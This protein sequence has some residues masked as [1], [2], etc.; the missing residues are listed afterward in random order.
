MWY[1]GE[2][3]E[4][5]RESMVEAEDIRHRDPCCHSKSTI[6]QHPIFL[7]PTNIRK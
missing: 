1:S 2:N 7:K 6:A 5:A 3:I 4:N